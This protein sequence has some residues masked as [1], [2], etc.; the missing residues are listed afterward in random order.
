MD[1]INSG[2]YGSDRY[3]YRSCLMTCRI[4]DIS[5]TPLQIE[6]SFQKTINKK[7]HNIGYQMVT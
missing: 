3:D 6:A 5:R 7:R 2:D 4:L 1:N